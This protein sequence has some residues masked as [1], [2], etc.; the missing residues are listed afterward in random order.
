VLLFL[1]IAVVVLAL[2]GLFGASWNFSDQLLDVTHAADA[3][4]LTVLARNGD[5]VTLPRSAITARGGVYG[6]YW[7]GGHSVVGRITRSGTSSV[8]RTLL[9]SALGLHAGIRARMDVFV[10][11]SLPEVH[12]NYRNVAVPGRLGVMPGWFVPGSR[13]TWVIVVHGY[14]SNRKEAL[15]VMPTLSHLG[16]PILDISYRNDSGAPSSPDHLYHLGASEWLD[17]ESATSY[18]LA[19]GAS[20][21]VLCGYSMGGNIVE[22]FLHRSSYARYTRAVVLDSPALDWSTILDRAAQNRGLPGILA[23]TTERVVAWRLGMFNLD[24]IDQLTARGGVVRPTLLFH[25]AGD[26]IVPVKSSDAFAR[27]HRSFVTYVRVPGGDHT[28]AWNLNP[29]RY[30]DAVKAFLSRAGLQ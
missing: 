6:L 19:H 10:Y 7:S 1:L 25:C 27:R 11:S 16:L 24:A 20:G 8:T 21:F 12:E 30:D 13:R 15:R 28:Q 17:L 22:S 4:D 18:A 23:V 29:A 3:Y 26:T 14:V 9:V 2:G 5:S